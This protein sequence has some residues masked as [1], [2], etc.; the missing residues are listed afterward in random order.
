MSDPEGGN[1]MPVIMIYYRHNFDSYSASLELISGMSNPE[2]GNRMPVIRI[3]NRHNVDANSASLELISG[4]SS[5]KG[6]IERLFSEYTI[7]T[8]FMLVRHP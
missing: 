6:E 2:G 1:R 8:C 7:D 4:M 3:Y 5:P